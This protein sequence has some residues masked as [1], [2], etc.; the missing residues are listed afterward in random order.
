MFNEV[1][2]P[3]VFKKRQASILA[4]NHHKKGYQLFGRL[5]IDFLI[6]STE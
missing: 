4:I 2:E 3:A 6:E 1:G 5:S